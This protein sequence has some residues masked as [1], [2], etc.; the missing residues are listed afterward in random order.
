VADHLRAAGLPTGLA[1][2]GI[3][4][5]GAALAAHM[6]H[7]KKARDGRLVLVLT[8][9]IGHAFLDD[10]VTPAEIEVFLQTV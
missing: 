6:L 3:A 5:D 2:A 4:A 9:G 10:S 8:R 1:D 7:D